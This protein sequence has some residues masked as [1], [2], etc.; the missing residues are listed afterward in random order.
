MKRRMVGKAGG[1][2]LVELLVTLGLGMLVLAAVSTTFMGQMRFYSAQAQVNEMEQNA[3]GAL[4][5]ITRELKMAGYN[6]AGAS[7]NG[8]TVSSPTQLQ[9]KADL[10]AVSGIQN[11][12]DENITYAYDNS[13]LQITRTRG[14]ETAQ[15][16]ADNITALTF[17]CYKADGATTTTTSSE[18]RQVKVEITARTAKPDPNSNGGYRTYVVT[19]TIT[20]INLGL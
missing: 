6:P 10:N 17:T 18:I 1:F 8:V 3:R 7:F 20:P 16:L 19:A 15:V 4:D 14:G 13:T 12:T 11:S 5:L 9:I 2:T